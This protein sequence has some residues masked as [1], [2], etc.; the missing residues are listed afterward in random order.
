VRDSSGTCG[1]NCRYTVKGTTLTIF[2]SGDMTDFTSNNM[3]WA[4]DKD[5]IKSV[6][7]QKN[8]T[9]IGSYAFYKFASLTSVTIP[10]TVKKIGNYSFSHA[11]LANLNL[12]SSVVSIGTNA[13]EYTNIAQLNIPDSVTS[14]GPSSFIYCANLAQV[15]IGVGLES[16]GDGAFF[17]CTKLA[18][19]AV[20]ESNSHF[21]SVENVLFDHDVSKLVVFAPAKT[22]TTYDIPATVKSLAV[23]AFAYAVVLD[24]VI[25][26][27]GVSV[28]SDGAFSYCTYLKNI[29][30]PDSVEAIGDSAFE[31]CTYLTTI[32]VPNGVVSIGKK[33]FA[34]CNALTEVSLS[35]SLISIGEG[36]F[37]SCKALK[38]MVLPDN[39]ES[40]GKSAFASCPALINISLPGS[41]KSIG[42]SAFASCT[43]LASITIPERVTSIERKAFNSCT[44]LQSVFY[45][46]AGVLSEPTVF[47]DCN[48]LKDICVSPDCDA[49]QLCG[50]FV[51]SSNAICKSFRSLFNHCY[52]GQYV[53]NEFVELKRK[54]TTE[55]E[56]RIEGCVHF[57]CD[58]A[59]G[60]IAWSLC[61]SSDEAS[62][63]C[64]NAECSANNTLR[65]GRPSLVMELVE[66][67]TVVDINS[68]IVL[69]TISAKCK[70]EKDILKVGWEANNQ[71]NVAQIV[72]YVDKEKTA[73]SMMKIINAM[74]KGAGCRAGILCKVN[75]AY[76]LEAVSAASTLHAVMKNIILMLMVTVI[77]MR[78]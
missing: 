30:I 46:G 40:I 55:W 58:N 70:V 37:S 67:V 72:A 29:T 71:G 39:V 14:I 36:A 62:L 9:S 23:Q 27:D 77:G 74:D 21:V 28:I 41:L 49:I 48:N 43:S 69:D 20:N 47:D 35:D 75:S 22:N 60:P 1:D 73:K 15:N 44:K 13:F 6:V 11:T 31:A 19:I 38:S 66:G 17:G 57:D 32:T 68:T 64:S 42:E 26:P 52:K 7:I 24:T 53:V 61:N 56:E 18:T 78:M 34:S 25:I 51:T 4:S 50:K 54:N 5:V 10:D 45:Q 33:A 63:V 59:T 76:V 2:G 8:V 12:P 65:I 16:I 3:P